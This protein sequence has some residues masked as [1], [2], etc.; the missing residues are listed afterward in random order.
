VSGVGVILDGGHAVDAVLNLLKSRLPWY[1]QEVAEQSGKPRDFY[2][3]PAQWETTSTSGRSRSFKYPAIL[4]MSTG[5]TGPATKYGDRFHQTFLVGVAALVSAKSQEETNTMARRYGGAI[6][7]A[8]LQ[9][10]SLGVDYVE[11][12]ALE[13]ED[14]DDDLPSGEDD[15]TLAS[16]RLVYSV[17]LKGVVDLKFAPG[18]F[19]PVF[20]DPPDADDPVSDPIP[21]GPPIEDVDHITIARE[22][23]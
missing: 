5:A 17:E 10:R 11:G 19:G 3:L 1:V 4:V 23:I 18:E 16:V 8:I 21:D 20:P 6:K 12:T 9:K 14:Y 13:S 22:S 2:A 7:A 15:Q